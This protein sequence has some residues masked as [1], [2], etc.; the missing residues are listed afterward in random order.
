MRAYFQTFPCGKGDCIFLRLVD[1]DDCFNIM[2]DCGKFDNAILNYVENDCRERIDLLIVTHYDA[3]HIEGITTMLQQ[4]P[5]LQIGKILFNTYKRN[6]NVAS[7]ELP[8]VLKQRLQD[9]SKMMPT[10]VVKDIIN[11]KVAARHAVTLS[12]TILNKDSWNAVWHK[13]RITKNT[14]NMP[15]GTDRKFGELL[16][17]SPT[18]SALDDLDREY[19]KYFM[20]VM[21]IGQAVD[22]DDNEN[23]YEML[24][25]IFVNNLEKDKISAS[26]IAYAPIT[27]NSNLTDYASQPL[28]P[29][30]KSNKASL[31][32]IWQKGEHRILFM[33]D[34]DPSVVNDSLIHKYNLHG[35]K[36]SLDAMKV[37]HH[38]SKDSTSSGLLN[39]IDT[40]KFII[41]G[42]EKELRPHINTL[43]RIILTNAQRQKTIYVNIP[44]ETTKT[45]NN[46]EGL[47]ARYH[48]AI[49]QDP[50]QCNYEF[51][52]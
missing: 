43:S 41:T 12:Q 42:G 48:Y 3:D 22:Y 20:Q 24:M 11:H 13:E 10:V 39:I 21:N 1:G 4:M 28:Q 15:L 25:R 33:G 26:K 38:G 51:E 35:N 7:V 9:L 18:E 14:S 37:S 23:L 32:F 49:V 17:L 36:L 52:V 44:N 50:D 6:P 29:M 5:D 45:L 16:F 8:D 2:V 34:A 30:T 19:K 31:A 46:S 47:K 27:D 40:D